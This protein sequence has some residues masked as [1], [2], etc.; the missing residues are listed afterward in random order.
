MWNTVKS[1]YRSISTVTIWKFSSS[2]L[3]YKLQHNLREK[4]PQVVQIVREGIFHTPLKSNLKYLQVY[5]F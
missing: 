5:N 4:F 2:T 3:P 1:F